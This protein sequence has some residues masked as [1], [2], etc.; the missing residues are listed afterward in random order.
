MSIGSENGMIIGHRVKPDAE[1]TIVFRVTFPDSIEK[2]IDSF[3]MTRG[4]VEAAI[5][6]FMAWEKQCR[7]QTVEWYSDDEND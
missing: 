6:S 1:R 3:E 7:Q 4:E 5:L 2:T